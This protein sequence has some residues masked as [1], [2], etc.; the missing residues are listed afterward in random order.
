MS[1][2]MK[3]M[4]THLNVQASFPPL[5]TPD[6]DAAIAKFYSE[7]KL[8]D[9]PYDD[10]WIQTHTGRKFFPLNPR[11]EDID[12]EDIAHALSMVCRYT[13]H[14]CEFYSVAEH[15]VLVSYFGDE[16]YGILHDASE[17]Y[18]ADIASPIKKMKEFQ[19]Y[20]QIE[21][22]LQTL[23][24]NNYGLNDPEPASL[25]KA[26]LLMLSTEA[27]YLLHPLHPEWKV[28]YEPLP[29]KLCCLPPKEAK[30]LFLKRF[31]ELF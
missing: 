31:K 30:E 3:A 20:R 13:G 29:I 22:T 15:S 27:H 1:K 9:Q 2:K 14:S 11:K 28:P 17:A 10:S 7:N 16:K 24:Y 6:E 18:I 4:N 26:D 21:S 8:I 12:I 25:K 5:T 23:I 19:F